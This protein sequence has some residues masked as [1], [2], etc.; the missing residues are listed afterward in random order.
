MHIHVRLAVF[1]SL[2]RIT[3]RRADDPAYPPAKTFFRPGN[4]HP[5]R[6]KQENPRSPLPV[7]VLSPANRCSCRGRYSAAGLDRGD[8]GSGPCRFRSPRQKRDDARWVTHPAVPGFAPALRVQPMCPVSVWEGLPHENQ[9]AEQP[10]KRRC[11]RNMRRYRPAIV[12]T[13]TG[14]LIS[15]SMSTMVSLYE[16]SRGEVAF[17][18]EC[19]VLI[20]AIRREIATALADIN[21]K[22]S[23]VL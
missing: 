10:G 20:S 17:H 3:A 18:R 11:S 5:T 16:Y 21:L 22:T 1:W 15:I 4:G 23:S 9:V 19:V 2:S 13:I 6:R 8:A 12:T 7:T 14:I